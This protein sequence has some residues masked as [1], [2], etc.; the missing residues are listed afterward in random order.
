MALLTQWKDEIEEKTDEGT[1]DILIYHRESKKGLK[2]KDISKY[3]V[4]ITTYG[5]MA[6]ELALATQTSVM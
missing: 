5:T 2:K 4:V 1:Y 3:D 6:A